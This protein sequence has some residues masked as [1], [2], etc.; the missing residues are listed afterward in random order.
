[1]GLYHKLHT[2]QMKNKMVKGKMNGRGRTNDVSV[3]HEGRKNTKR[4]SP[5]KTPQCMKMG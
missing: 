4:K 5:C 1:M 2:S 3:I